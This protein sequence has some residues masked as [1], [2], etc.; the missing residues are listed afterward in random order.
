MKFSV[1]PIEKLRGEQ[2]T[3]APRFPAHR[4]WPGPQR[5]RLPHGPPGP[6][7]PSPRGAHMRSWGL[8]G[9]CPASEPRTG[10][11]GVVVLRAS[12]PDEETVPFLPS[13]G[14][15]SLQIPAGDDGGQPAAEGPGRVGPSPAAPVDLEPLA[16]GARLGCLERPLLGQLRSGL[17]WPRQDLDTCFLG[18]RW[19]ELALGMDRPTPALKRYF[20]EIPLLLEEKKNSD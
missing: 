3:S 11:Q 10:E 19:G 14:Q 4:A 1:L 13:A 8:S 17:H 18:R 15:K 12:G 16:S 9:L 2:R 5:P 7:A 20:Q 6:S